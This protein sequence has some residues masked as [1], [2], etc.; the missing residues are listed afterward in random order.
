MNSL[1]AD[2]RP[3]LAI[4]VPTY[5]RASSLRNLLRSLDLVKTRYGEDI[6][7]CISNNGSTDETSN[8]IEDFT[9]KHAVNVCHQSSNIGGTL[10]IIAVAGQ[11]RACWGIWCGDD[12]EFNLDG[13]GHLLDHLRTL[14][15]SVWLLVDSAGTDGRGLYM[16]HIPKGDFDAAGFRSIMLRGG[17]DP[18][19]FMGVHVFPKTAVK[20]LQSFHLLDAQPWPHLAAL[21]RHIMQDNTHVST[22][23]EIVIHQAK[24]GANL[25]WLAGDFV[26][27]HL[28][29]L[30][31]MQFAATAERGHQ[32]FL[33]LLM[34]REVYTASRFGL[35]LAWK[36]YEPEDFNAHAWTAY[37]EAWCRLGIWLPLALPHIFAT[38]LVRLTP[39][40]T[41]AFL[42]RLTGRAHYIERYI[43]R[44]QDLQSFDGIKRGI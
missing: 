36:V 28:S 2:V 25:F 10:N 35:M 42:L 20:I 32:I 19:G 5:N 30:R 31:I 14:P 8:Y 9:R 4:C 22:R 41:M 26:R 27:I 38:V 17:S 34:L 15:A 16:S 12:D 3:L 23:R 11:M 39:H 7:I 40:S 1:P 44:K 29:K 37:R 13:I 18:Y 24:G 33:H 43:Q 21:L 6:E